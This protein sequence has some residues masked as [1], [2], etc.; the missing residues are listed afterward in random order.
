MGKRLVDMGIW[1]KEF[2]RAF[3]DK[4]KLLYLCCI[5]SEKTGQSGIIT[6]G[7]ISRELGW[8]ANEVE[9]VAIGMSPKI[10]VDGPNK[11]ILVTKYFSFHCLKKSEDGDIIRTMARSALNDCE[12][13][14]ESPLVDIIRLSSSSFSSYFEANKR[15]SQDSEDVQKEKAEI[16]SRSERWI[17]DT[18]GKSSIRIG[19]EASR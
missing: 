3:D 5:T 4:Q 13:V 8:S 16:K 6:I 9:S 2:F 11:L 17:F 1:D 7:Q 18:Y 14:L 19:V 10:I 12:R 15:I